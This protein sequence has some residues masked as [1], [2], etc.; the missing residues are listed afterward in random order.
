MVRQRAK[1][2]AKKKKAQ[3]RATKKPKPAKIKMKPHGRR[4][5]GK[6][7]ETKVKKLI[8]LAKSRKL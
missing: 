2:T 3:T 6:S 1:K 4:P 7:K 8:E 5:S